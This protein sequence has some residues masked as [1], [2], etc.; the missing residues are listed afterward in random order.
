MTN[1]KEIDIYAMAYGGNG[2]GKIDGKICFVE[3]ALPGERVCF[4]PMESKKNFIRGIA[5]EILAPSPDR[6]KPECK[7]YGTCGGC[8]YQHLTY[9]KEL[10]FKAQQAVDMMRRIG[11]LNNF[12]CESIAGAGHPY[13]YRASITLH[14]SSGGYGY[15]AKD[16]KT[17][18]DIDNCPLAVH[19]INI[20]IPALFDIS[21]KKNT[22]I[23]SDSAGNAYISNLHGNRFYVDRFLDTDITF[24][25][26]AF[27][28][29]NPQMATCMA[30]WLRESMIKHSAGKTLFDLFCGVGFFGVLMRDLFDTIIGIDNSSIAIDCAVQTKKS[31]NAENIRFYCADINKDFIAY[32]KKMGKAPSVILL[33]PPRSG[34]DSALAGYLADIDNAG[35][36]YYVSC[37]PATLA[38]DSKIITKSGKWRLA[39][40]K[41]FDMFARTKHIEIIAIFKRQE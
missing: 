22:T 28:Q 10:Q 8:Q 35:L 14:R 25:P 6:V 4:R 18:I 11:G 31:L 29:A 39:R 15:Y 3:G 7:Y 12:E 30:L 32:Y 1:I 24:S 26:L 2:I 16:N 19:A 5:V 37:D 27:S 33:D 34:L 21:K 9:A 40:I 13:G 17:I 41:C 36:L 20:K 38:R 23:K